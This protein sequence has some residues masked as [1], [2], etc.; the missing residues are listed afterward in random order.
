ML[1]VTGLDVDF[2]FQ[3]FANHLKIWRWIHR[4]RIKRR[5][6]GFAVNNIWINGTAGE[7]MA[8]SK[9]RR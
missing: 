9:V 8:L 1:A 5:A 4:R 6:L 3:F 7:L 2:S